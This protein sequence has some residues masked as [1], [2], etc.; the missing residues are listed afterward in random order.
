MIQNTKTPLL[1]YSLVSLTKQWINFAHSLLIVLAV[2]VVFPPAKL[3]N[4]IWVLPGFLIT[5]LFLFFTV[6]LMSIL[7][8]RF[9]DIQP[10]IS[11]IMP[12]LF[13]L[14]PVLFRI[15]Q[16]KNISWLIW[17]NPF[18]YFIIIIRE[19]LQGSQPEPFVLLVAC[20][21]TLLVFMLLTGL[22]HKKRNQ[23][24]YWV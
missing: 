2:S 24:V 19:P 4:I 9:R 11:S 23:V 17:I 14:S 7:C 18:T 1:F 12:M 8:A 22:L 5:S 16:A 21:L 3:L 10:L 6:G 15:E 13:F 20:G